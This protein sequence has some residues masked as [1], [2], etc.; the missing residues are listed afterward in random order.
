MLFSDF[1][2][3]V[4]CRTTELKVTGAYEAYEVNFVFIAVQSVGI[5]Y[6]RKTIHGLLRWKGV[7]IGQNRIS[8]SLVR[9]APVPMVS[10]WHLA[11]RQLNPYPY[12]ALYFGEKLHVDQNEKLNRFGSVT[13][14]LAGDG[15]SR[16]IVVLITIPRKNP[17]AIYHALMRPLLISEG[18]WDQVRVD[19]GAEFT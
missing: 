11:H 9:V 16:K 3:L 1:Y 15:F 6:G 8:G 4:G 2:S 14:I 10:R 5:S 7:H 18:L 17:I 19:H 12:N 13:H